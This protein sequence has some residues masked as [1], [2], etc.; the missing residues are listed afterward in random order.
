MRWTLLFSLF[1]LAACSR[2]P[3][4]ITALS[5]DA[6]PNTEPLPPQV[7]AAMWKVRGRE[8]VT[9]EGKPV[10]L[11]GIV[12]GNWASENE[13][14]PSDHHSEEDFRRVAKMGMNTIRFYTSYRTF[15]EDS[16]PGV[17][18][19]QGFAWIDQNIDWAR[20]YGIRLVLTMHSPVGGPQSRGSG[21]A[22]WEDEKNQA[23]FV[24][25]WRAISERYRAEPTI[26][27]YGLLN[28][29]APPKSTEQWRDLANRTIAEIREVDQHHM[30]FVGRVSDQNGRRPADEN[31]NFVRVDDPNVVHEFHFEEPFHFTHQNATWSA[32]AAR[33]ARYPDEETPEVDWLQLT[34][35]AKAESD[36]LE[37]GDSEWTLLET[38]PLEVPQEGVV[39]GRPSL[40]CDDSGGRAFFDTLALSELEPIREEQGGETPAPAAQ[41][42]TIFEVDLD[43]RRGWTFENPSGTG[44][45]RLVNQG[46]GDQTA[47]SILNTR[48]EAYLSSET[49]HFFAKPGRRYQLSAL[50][51]GAA[52]GP[53]ANCRL[54]LQLHS[55]KISVL[56]R[57]KDYLAQELDEY[58]AWGEKAGVPLY[59]GEFGTIR[60]S[61]L[62]GRGG[63][64]WARDMLDLILERK[65][66]FAYYAYH[67]VPFGLFVGDSGLPGIYSAN[68]L[69]YEVLVKAL[70]GPDADTRLEPTQP[71]AL[72]S[73]TDDQ[74]AEE[75]PGDAQGEEDSSYDTLDDFD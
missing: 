6:P 5:T 57:G 39:I 72:P 15:E 21:N 51:R 74:P 36:P 43:T 25:L 19:E 52:L 45:A 30:I 41:S 49:L 65:L 13:P 56:P 17:Y 67:E 29:P 75:A 59:L 64:N 46:H 48:G 4:P 8:I 54:R 23:R 31:R 37:E 62:P 18:S 50:G 66:G 14:I 12:F 47:L 26:A 44:E 33:E 42:E 69:L 27:G 71:R 63:Q 24:A 61:F 73:K 40:V 58:L 11:R 68:M 1:G 20:R 3:P 28:E 32:I 55:S 7:L 70:V 60:D 9:A 22:L 38:E 53:E 34:T 16:N 35:V 2:T 10:H